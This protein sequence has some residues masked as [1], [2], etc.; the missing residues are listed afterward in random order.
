MNI[1]QLDWKNCSDPIADEAIDSVE[2]RLGVRFPPSFRAAVK[3][4]HGGYPKIGGFEYL[5]PESNE[6]YGSGLGR[7]LSF[8]VEEYENIVDRNERQP[9]G[10]PQG[11]VIFGI[12]GGSGYICFNYQDMGCVDPPVVFWTFNTF[13]EETIIPLADSFNEFIEI[14]R[15]ETPLP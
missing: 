7:L 1:D 10:M 9:E 8:N 15:P 6:I 3:K 11:L 13:S 5:D 2:R 4:Y 14:L 12:D